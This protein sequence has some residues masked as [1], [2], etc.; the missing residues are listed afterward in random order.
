MDS[1]RPDD[2]NWDMQAIQHGWDVFDANGDKVGDVSDVSAGYVTVS[3]GFIFTSDRYIPVSA[4][5]QTANDRV[6]LNVTK[7]EIDMRGWDEMPE[8]GVYAQTQRQSTMPRT[9]TSTGT[10][11]ASDDDE[12]LKLRE[13]RLRADKQRVQTGDV[14]V[15]KRVVTEQQSIDVPVSHEEVVVEQH[16]VDPTRRAEGDIDEGEDREIHVPVHGEQVRV[17][18][19]PV[20]YGEVDVHKRQVQDTQRVSGTA[21]RE[22]ARVNKKGDDIDIDGFDEDRDTESHHPPS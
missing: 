3:K 8:T 21:R 7:D 20:V 1:M 5:E 13:E 4:I 15:G 19:E 17:E 14:S 10:S 16:P 12:T 2:A 11:T 22:E 18:K 6:Y 9:G